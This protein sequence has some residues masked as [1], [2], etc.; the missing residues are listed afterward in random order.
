MQLQK[1]TAAMRGFHRDRRCQSDN[2]AP[3]AYHATGDVRGSFDRAAPSRSRTIRCDSVSEGHRRRLMPRSQSANH[4]DRLAPSSNATSHDRDDVLTEGGS[5]F[6]KRL[7]AFRGNLI[8]RVMRKWSDDSEAKDDDTCHHQKHEVSAVR[9]WEIAA[10][11]QSETIW[12]SADTSS[13]EAP[14]SPSTPSSPSPSP[15][16][17][18]FDR[19][20]VQRRTPRR[21]RTVVVGE[22]VEA[23]RGLL[24]RNASNASSTNDRQQPKVNDVIQHRSSRFNDDAHQEDDN[25]DVASVFSDTVAHDDIQQLRPTR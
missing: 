15:C 11:H 21:H 20:R 19:R 25:S 6:R 23:A 9:Q 17:R 16:T 12:N 14:S 24:R 4:I 18:V 1:F 3:V 2:V 13:V 10:V 7:D 22:Q 5:R 8:A